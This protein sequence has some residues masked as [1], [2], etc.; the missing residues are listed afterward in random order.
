V[1][2]KNDGVE[3]PRSF[4]DYSVIPP[5]ADLLPSG[6]TYIDGLVLA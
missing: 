5:A 4:S 1:V 6:V 3:T 2:K